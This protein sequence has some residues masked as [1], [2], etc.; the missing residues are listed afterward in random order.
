MK[1]QS[2]RAK[3]AIVGIGET[4]VGKLPGKTSMQLMAE[5]SAQAIEDAGLKK[6][7][8]DGVLVSYSLAEPSFMYC[9]FFSEYMGIKPHFSAAVHLGGASMC[10]LVGHA[11]AAINAGI[12]STV[13]IA[14]GDPQRT[15]FS[16]QG[17]VAMSTEVGHRQF[18][19]P[20]APLTAGIYAM[21]ARRHMHE[22][23]TTSEQLAEIAVT[24]R[25]HASMNDN[26]QMRDPITIDDVLN[27]KLVADPLHVLDCCLVSDGGGAIVVTSAERANDLR[28]PPVY[29]LGFGEGH[30]HYHIIQAESLVTSGCKDAARRA[31]AMSGLT[32]A[33]IDVAEIYDCF[34]TTVLVDLE[35]LGFC[36]KGEGGRFV[37][38][39]RITFGGEL[40][41]NTHGGLLSQAHIAGMLHIVEAARQL[42]GEAGRR[43][44]HGAQTAVVTGNGG[45]L[46]AHAVLVL[47]TEG[48]L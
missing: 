25:Y 12:C 22:F 7:D 34:T 19:A 47:G 24:M 31:F 38:G 36:E 30:S 1:E 17:V 33:D 5:A 20:Y 32:P 4:A 42:R 13:L 28:K 14:R 37:Q 2:I 3:T 27:S 46:S 18:E 15:G 40:P 29:I 26:A 41:V 6:D 35:D 39:G 16:R 8:V 48:V 44:V 45:S 10:S 9:S 23:G 43:Q 11:A 21:V